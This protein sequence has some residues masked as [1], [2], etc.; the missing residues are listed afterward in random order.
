MKASATEVCCLIKHGNIW[1]LETWVLSKYLT[2][3]VC[4]CVW[5]ESKAYQLLKQSVMQTRLQNCEEEDADDDS[6]S[7]KRCA[8][9][10]ANIEQ[11]EPSVN[12]GLMVSHINTIEKRIFVVY[13]QI[14]YSKSTR[15]ITLFSILCDEW[16]KW[17]RTTRCHSLSLH[18]SVAQPTSGWCH[19]QRLLS[20]D[21][22]AE[23]CY[24]VCAHWWARLSS[25][26]W[27]LLLPSIWNK[28][29]GTVQNYCIR[30]Y[31]DL[32]PT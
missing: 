29:I 4:V 18:K 8:V 10:L 14:N 5:T 6:F 16:H 3:C 13:R 9:H 7:G 26:S 30:L 21:R 31:V 11:L 22:Q 24:Q 28:L 23:L 12:P 1:K 20:S 25:Q 2:V 15:T 32:S 19:F 27:R 17:T